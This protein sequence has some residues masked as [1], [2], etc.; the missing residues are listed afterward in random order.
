MGR[1]NRSDKKLDQLFG[2]KSR[3]GGS[4]TSVNASLEQV[5]PHAKTGAG[6]S[7]LSLDT[8]RLRPGSLWNMI[9][10]LGSKPPGSQDTPSAPIVETSITYAIDT[11][12]HELIVGWAIHSGGIETI[13]V[14]RDGKMIGLAE[15]GLVRLD[16]HKVFPEI[17][18]SSKS[19]FSFHLGAHLEE[20]SF[21]VTLEFESRDGTRARFSKKVMKVSLAESPCEDASRRDTDQPLRSGFPYQIT[22]LLRKFLPGTYDI[23][24][25]W[26]DDLM[27]QAANDLCLLWQGGARSPS[28]NKYI[29][30]LKTMHHRFQLVHSMFPKYNQISNIKSKDWIVAATSPAELLSIANYL[31]ILKSHGLHG[32]FL[33]FGCFKGH[34]SCCLSYCCHELDIPM[35]IFDSFA[36]LPPSDSTYYSAGDFCGTRAE[37]SANIEELGTP[38]VVS[39]NEGYF[40]DTLPHFNKNP[41]ICIWM[42]VDLFT[43]AQDVAQILD[44]LPARSALF[45]HE[46]PPD[47]T[48]AGR[49]VPEVS[50]VFPPILDRLE[51]L[52]RKPVGRYL[53]GMLGAI[54]DAAQGI[55]VMPHECLM[56][57]VHL[58]DF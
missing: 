13:R 34:S 41:V 18:E 57:L 14:F 26:T 48:S 44:R 12:D 32:H 35:E 6:H 25:C 19:G 54:W 53:N 33:E 28:L 2:H 29:L 39:L 52:G 58:G 45:T 37:V 5:K 50:E 1:K 10:R 49:V 24:S 43:S 21:E 27:V 38:Q 42:D 30:F 55:P 40:S 51:S 4:E 15:L 9:G 46:F 3:S 8:F 31:Y 23:E 47:G 16:V 56:K 11:F 36:G 7:V 22:H 17:A 20:G